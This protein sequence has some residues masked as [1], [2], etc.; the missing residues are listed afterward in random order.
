MLTSVNEGTPLSLI[1]AQVCGKPVVAT[2][3]GGVRD[4]FFKQY[5]RFSFCRRCKKNLQA[6][7]NACL[8]MQPC[9]G[10]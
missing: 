3:V 6:S 9:A 1:E 8:I 5:F 2:D 7:C 10:K 4:T